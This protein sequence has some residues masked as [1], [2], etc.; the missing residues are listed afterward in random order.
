MPAPLLQH[1]PA[2]KGIITQ[3]KL[4]V[5]APQTLHSQT[6]MQTSWLY[7]ALPGKQSQ[8]LKRETNNVSTWG[9]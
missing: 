6:H 2:L 7:Q 5:R 4:D 8:V 1:F 9:I 3:L